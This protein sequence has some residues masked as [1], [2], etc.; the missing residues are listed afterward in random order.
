MIAWWIF[1][2]LCTLIGVTLTVLAIREE[3]D[4]NTVF[5]GLAVGILSTAFTGAAWLI[6]FM[7]KV[8]A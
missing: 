5:F 3:R 1:P 4:N 8:L 2:A 7:L 6:G